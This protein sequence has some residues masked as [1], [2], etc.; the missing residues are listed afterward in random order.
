MITFNGVTKLDPEHHLARDL[1]NITVKGKDFT[2]Q[3]AGAN[4]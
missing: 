1:G 3:V 4:P 2:D